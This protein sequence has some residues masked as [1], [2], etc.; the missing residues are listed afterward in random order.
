VSAYDSGK[1]SSGF[2]S[3]SNSN[4]TITPAPSSYDCSPAVVVCTS[5]ES[6]S[7]VKTAAKVQLQKT[8]HA[9]NRIV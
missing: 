1:S 4:S 7:V 9:K 5:E 6:K 8:V 2:V 3:T